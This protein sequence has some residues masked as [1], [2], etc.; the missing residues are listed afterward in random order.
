MEEQAKTEELVGVDADTIQVYELSIN[1]TTL[2]CRGLKTVKNVHG[3]FGLLEI[4]GSAQIGGD[5]RGILSVKCGG[6]LQVDGNLNIS[7]DLEVGHTLT[8]A[9]TNFV[10]GR[11]TVGDGAYINAPDIPDDFPA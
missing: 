3:N 5:L 7:G 2:K 11:L 1:K 8:V 9:G 4:A 6:N 10:T